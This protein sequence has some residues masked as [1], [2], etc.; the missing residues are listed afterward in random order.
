MGLPELSSGWISGLV[1]GILQAGG[2]FVIASAILYGKVR[3]NRFSW[4]IWSAVASLAAAGSWQAGA[5]WP[6]AGAAMNALG[7]MVVFGLSLRIGFFA[8]STV[9]VAC[10][11]AACFGIV[12]WLL[13]SDPV[14][15]LLL[16]LA[17]DA[18]G[19]VPTVRNVTLD[20]DCE[21][22]RGWA[23]LAVAGAAA[24][25]SVEPHQWAWS[26]IGFGHWGGAVYVALVNALVTF[27]IVASRGMRTYAM[28]DARAQTVPTPPAAGRAAR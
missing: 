28:L 22:V 10:L 20:P 1:A 16:F 23:L 7:C 2:F 26:W 4:L 9:D 3:P 6:L 27:S 18:C 14:A 12:A 19:A 13:S 25:L 17:A 21:S 5:T 11:V 24:V 8:A 15:G